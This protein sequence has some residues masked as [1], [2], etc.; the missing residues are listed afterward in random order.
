MSGVG[1]ILFMAKDPAM[2][3]Y[4]NDWNSG[5]VTLSRH[6]KGCYIDLLHAQFNS[7]HLSLEEIKTVLGSDFGS[8]WPTLQK[9]FETDPKGLFFNKRLEEEQ[10]KRKAFAESRRENR[11]SNHMKDHMSPHME[12]ENRDEIRIEN[13]SEKTFD[14]RFLEAFD[15]RT[16]EVLMMTFKEIPKEAWGRELQE[17]RTKCDLSPQDYHKRDTQ[18]LRQGFQYQLKNYRHGKRAT[19]I[20]DKL[21]QLDAILAARFG[22]EGTK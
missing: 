9:K 7:G 12:N 2:L 3:W 19:K 5:T 14:E 16:C 21:S 11:M 4:W 10:S 6:L 8:S 17:Y 1:A 15:E 22:A 18:G 13:G 20:G